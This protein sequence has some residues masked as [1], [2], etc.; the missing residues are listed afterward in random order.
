MTTYGIDTAAFYTTQY[1]L[2][3]ETLANS[4]GVDPTRFTQGLGQHKMAVIPPDEG[5]V[6]LAANAAEQAL[7]KCDKSDIDLLLFATESGIDQSKAAGI[8]VHHLL[9]LPKRCRVL[10]L[11]QACYSATAGLQLALSHLARHPDKKVLLVA[12]DIARY[13]LNT[14]GESS[15]GGAAV[16]MVLSANPRLMAVD[17][18]SGYH[19]EDAMDFW[20]P[21]YR[22]E[23]LVDGRHSCELYLKL[24]KETW[25]QYHESSGR[26]FLDHDYFCYHT[27]LPKL[28]ESAHQKLAFHNGFRRKDMDK[29]NQRM[30]G[31]LHYSRIVGNC[32]AGS[33]Y[34]GII[35]LLDNT[36]DDFSNKRLGL[37]S[38][39]S[40]CT[41]EFYSGVIQPGYEK[42]LHTEYHQQLIANREELD[43]AA[44]EGFYSFKYPTDGSRFIVPK[45]KTGNFRLAALDQHKRI[46][47][48]IN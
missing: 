17:S 2:D 41:A 30:G 27:P 40:G 16:A 24:L 18:H 21:N 4:R 12:S 13:G 39:G 15:Q 22:E 10:E 28:A 31:F 8:Y 32:Y 5:V 35:S 46:Y 43:Q 33:L 29:I 6:T 25:R 36:K 45:N 7:T 42:V 38:Y 20:R 47:E 1:Y 23:A 48:K 9:D 26:S 19:T 44:Y 3:L 11:K 37:Y 14:T 34:L